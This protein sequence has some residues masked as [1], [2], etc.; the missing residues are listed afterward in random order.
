MIEEYVQNP[1]NSAKLV[2]LTKLSTN[3][4]SNSLDMNDYREYVDQIKDEIKDEPGFEDVDAE[5]FS[6]GLVKYLYE[7]R[8]K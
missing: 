6:L 5:E 4:L 1:E 2:E 8:S 7:Q 3:Y